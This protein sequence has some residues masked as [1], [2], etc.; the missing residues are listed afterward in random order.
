MEGL[1]SE[2]HTQG[3]PYIH[4]FINLPPL[5]QDQLAAG[6]SPLAIDQN[7]SVPEEIKKSHV[8][9]ASKS[10]QLGTQM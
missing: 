2:G 5:W 1:E 9:D 7:L 10:N 4:P 6:T 3:L 8:F